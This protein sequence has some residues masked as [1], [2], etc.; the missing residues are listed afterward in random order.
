MIRLG[1]HLKQLMLALGD[2]A[3]F[4]LALVLA[5]TIR[6]NGWSEDVWATH[7]GP[8]SL[9]FLLWL[10]GFYVAGLY[11]LRLIQDPLKLFRNYTEG[12]VGNLLMA[13]A[14]FYLHPGLSISPRTNLLIVVALTFLIGYIW[15][16]SFLRLIDTRLFHAKALYI[17]PSEEIPTIQRLLGSSALG[18]TLGSAF[19]TSGEPNS[20]LPIKWL[21]DTSALEEAVQDQQINIIILGVSIDTLEHLHQTLYRSLFHSVT[22]IDRMELEETIRGRICLTEVKDTWFI[23]HLRES[24]KSWYDS[25]KRAMDLM[26]A[27]PFSIA[28]ILLLPFIALAIRASSTGPLFYTQT[29]VGR[30]GQEFSIWKFR[31]MRVDAEKNGPQFTSSTKTDPRITSVGRILRQLR[32]DELPQLWNVIRGDLSFIGPRPERPEFVTPLV[33]R[34]PYYHLRHLTRP[35]LTGWAQVQWLTP[36]TSLDDNLIKLQY[37]LYYIKNRSFLLDFSILLKTIGIVL[38][39]QGT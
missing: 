27:V 16:V 25:C 38:R 1:Q 2:Y 5:L 13:F 24:E 19:S 10:A 34:M 17:G 36:T 29:R 3:V 32:L 21:K 15:R 6:Y 23:Q 11:N 12:M 7:A 30:N 9:I 39:R 18:L 22:L 26:L 35:G 31:T 4:S 20:T 14:F 8:F 37:D 28:T 33:A